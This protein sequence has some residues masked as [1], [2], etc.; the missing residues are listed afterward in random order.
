MVLCIPL[1]HLPS[2]LNQGTQLHGRE[3]GDWHNGP[4]PCNTIYP[5]GWKVYFGLPRTFGALPYGSLKL[6]QVHNNL[7]LS[8]CDGGMGHTGLINPCNLF[9]NSLI[10]EYFL[11][12]I[13]VFNSL[14][15]VG[16]AVWVSSAALVGF[17]I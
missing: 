8:T 10:A 3:Q 1:L 12:E 6:A 13:T 4:F 9:G 11:R 7:A 5:Y 15:R 16:S 14:S 17:S 2:T